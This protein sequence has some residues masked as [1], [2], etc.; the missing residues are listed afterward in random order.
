MEIELN[1]WSCFKT[2]K[3]NLSSKSVS[4]TI[5]ELHE[6]SKCYCLM[7]VNDINFSIMIKKGT[8]DATD[9]INNYQSSAVICHS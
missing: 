1:S 9:Y 8:S 6:T 2:L 5:Y 7:I 4:Y 3:T